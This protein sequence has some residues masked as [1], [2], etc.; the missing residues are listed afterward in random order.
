MI[1]EHASGYNPMRYNCEIDGCFN[2]KKRPKIEQFADC[3]PS[4][5]NFTDVDGIVEIGGRGLLLEWKPV[6]IGMRRTG[7]GI[8]Y[9]ELTKGQVLTVICLAGNAETMEISHE[10]SFVAGKFYDWRPSSL[11][12]AQVSILR[13]VWS[14]CIEQNQ[15]HRR[16]TP[17]E[18]FQRIRARLK[19]EEAWSG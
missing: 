6:P 10:A 8:M 11:F 17:T 7:Q 16:W 12:D 15:R 1:P 4:G 3:F 2:R 13:W 18:L 9:R 19:E 5:I 14:T